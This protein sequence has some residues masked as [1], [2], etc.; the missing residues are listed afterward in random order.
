MSS[1]LKL[2][3]TSYFHR[4]VDEEEEE[5]GKDDESISMRTKAVGNIDLHAKFKKTKKNNNN[6]LEI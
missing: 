6:R 2:R 5:L 4:P 1:P 3:K